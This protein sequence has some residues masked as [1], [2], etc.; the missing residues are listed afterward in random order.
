MYDNKVSELG[1]E[2]GAR[3]PPPPRK[4]W[5]TNTSA[6]SVLRKP[7]ESTAE[8]LLQRGSAQFDESRRGEGLKSSRDENEGG[9][10]SGEGGEGPAW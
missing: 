5:N 2:S 3:V 1:L 6:V 8:S 4:N 10:R 7:V 9:Y